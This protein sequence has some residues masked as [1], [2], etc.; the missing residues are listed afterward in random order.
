MPKFQEQNLLQIEQEKNRLA[1][2]EET[3]GYS[4]C[5]HCEHFDRNSMDKN[6]CKL[7]PEIPGEVFYNEWFCLGFVN[8]S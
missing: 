7:C 3:F 1:D 6:K 8:N 5:M 2:A 4:P